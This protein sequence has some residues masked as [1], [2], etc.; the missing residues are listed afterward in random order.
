MEPETKLK[1]KEEVK[2]RQLHRL[3]KVH[4]C[5]KMRPGSQTLLAA[6]KESP[7][8]N[9]QMTAIRYISG[10]KGML[11]A[12]WSN[13]QYDGLATFE[14]SEI[15]PLPPALSSMDLPG[16]WTKLLNVL[17]IKKIDCHPTDSDQHGASESISDLHHWL[18]WNGDLDNPNVTVKTR[19]IVP[20]LRLSD[21]LH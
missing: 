12:S 15:S 13:L 2:E 14:L 9:K 6:K 11:K 1:L 7:A 20:G 4:N 21:N 19:S 18:N 3:A 10:S 17:R 16:G 8:Q 5:L